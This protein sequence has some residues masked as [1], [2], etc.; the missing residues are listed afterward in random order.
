VVNRLIR[1]LSVALV[2]LVVG[3]SEP[4]KP[5]EPPA[6]APVAR[7]PTG[8]Y[9]VKADPAVDLAAAVKTAMASHKRIMLVV[10]GEWCSW[11]HILDAY[12]KANPDIQQTWNERYVTLFVN[13]SEENRN[14]LFL[15]KYPKISGYPHI[16]VLETSGE[17]LH[18][19]DTALLEEGRSYSKVKM[20][21]FLDRWR[22]ASMPQTF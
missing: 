1:V 11:C 18:S 13:W 5:A 15:S 3:C 16:F 8:H 12:I 14:D 6:P 2:A 17:L 4:P 22:L 20:R 7:E 9:D 10:G 19:Q 21:E